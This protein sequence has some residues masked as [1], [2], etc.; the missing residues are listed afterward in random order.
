MTVPYDLSSFAVGEQEASDIIFNFLSAREITL[1]EASGWV[2]TNPSEIVT[3]TMTIDGVEVTGSV[4]SIGT[5]GTVT[6]TFPNPTTLSDGELLKIVLNSDADDPA[7]KV[8][9]VCIT[10]K[11]TIETDHDDPRYDISFFIEGNIPSNRTVAAAI[12]QRQINIVNTGFHFKKNTEQQS[13]LVTF[14]IRNNGTQI[15]SITSSTGGATTLILNTSP[16]NFAEG[17]VFSIFAPGAEDDFI[18][19]T[20]ADVSVTFK[21]F[22]G[23]G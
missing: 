5:D 8:G 4:V 11:G 2:E 22:L 21:G 16:Y 13:S 9:G 23:L 1:T 17:D 19:T 6:V 7:T 20:L 12:I 10:F 15:G 3:G 18:D 14:S